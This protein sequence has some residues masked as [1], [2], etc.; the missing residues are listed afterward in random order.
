MANYLFKA[1]SGALGVKIAHT[2]EAR[3]TIVAAAQRDGRELLV[4]VLG[5]SDIYTDTASLLDWAFQRTK[6]ICT[7]HGC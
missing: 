1:Y 3:Y 6:A 4:T 5:S 2:V 7:S